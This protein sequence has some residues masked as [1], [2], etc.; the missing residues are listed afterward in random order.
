MRATSCDTG[1]ARS[2][3][4]TPKL[5]WHVDT[6]VLSRENLVMDAMEENEGESK[7]IQTESKSIHPP[8]CENAWATGSRALHEGLTL[9]SHVDSDGGPNATTWNF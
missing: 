3:K 7:K 9:S 2:P 6:A 4:L 8:K 5:H 1:C